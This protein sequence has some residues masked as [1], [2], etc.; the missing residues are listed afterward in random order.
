MAR[1]ATKLNEDASFPSPAQNRE[2]QQADLDASFP[3]TKKLGHGQPAPN[4]PAFLKPNSF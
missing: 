2:R 1:R 3:K 4:S